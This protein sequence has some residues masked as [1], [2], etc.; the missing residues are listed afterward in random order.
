MWPCAPPYSRA[1][2]S[3]TL[4]ICTSTLC[5][6]NVHTPNADKL[7]AE[8]ITL[9]SHCK[10]SLAAALWRACRVHAFGVPKNGSTSAVLNVPRKWCTCVRACVLEVRA[11]GPAC[12]LTQPV[13][14]AVCAHTCD[15]CTANNRHISMVCAHTLRLHDWYE[16]ALICRHAP[17]PLPK[18][19]CVHTHMQVSR[20]RCAVCQA[21]RARGC[22]SRVVRFER[23]HAHARAYYQRLTCALLHNHGCNYGACVCVRAC[24]QGDCHTTSFRHRIT[25]TVPSAC[26]P[27]SCIRCFTAHRCAH[28][29][30]MY[31]HRKG[32]SHPFLHRHL[33]LSD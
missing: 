15:D 8:G 6:G 13:P 14:V 9:D 33:S 28:R 11:G 21:A 30:C 23:Q 1:F 25:W 5:Q 31:T 3:P 4:F 16:G 29:Y 18:A 12:V 22:T 19:S 10:G 24:L 17:E 7:S 20:C 27:L 26:C 32:A 2:L